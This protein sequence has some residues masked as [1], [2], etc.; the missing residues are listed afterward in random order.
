MA[1]RASDD[2]SDGQD[3]RGLPEEYPGDVL[4]GVPHRAQDRYLLG[5]FQDDHGQ[6][7]EHREARDQGEDGD[8]DG[9]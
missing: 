6:G 7:V 9:R 1:P 5:L 2:R 4:A 8:G 3:D